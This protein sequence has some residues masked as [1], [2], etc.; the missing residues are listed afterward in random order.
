MIRIERVRTE[1]EVRGFRGSRDG[2]L[3]RLMT[4]Q[5]LSALIARLRFRVCL[6]GKHAKSQ[7][8]NGHY[9]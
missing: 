9:S 5:S 7:V 4:S 1:E 2:K 8:T 6:R 3:E